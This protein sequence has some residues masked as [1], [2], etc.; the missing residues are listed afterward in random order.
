M[1]SVQKK[2]NT[3]KQWKKKKKTEV[4]HEPSRIMGSTQFP[5]DIPALVRAQCNDVVCGI[6][7][8]A[9]NGSS[10][11]PGITSP[12]TIIRRTPLDTIVWRKMIL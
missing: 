11:S 6:T 1:N 2:K 4:S 10:R 7:Y 3:V 5:A 12:H 9:V 8:K